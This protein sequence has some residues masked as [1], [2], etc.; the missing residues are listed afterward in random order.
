V[1]R[2]YLVFPAL[3]PVTALCGCTPGTMQH[4][5]AVQR[6]PRTTMQLGTSRETDAARPGYSKSLADFLLLFSAKIYLSR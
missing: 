1:P 6:R 5:D 3:I 4:Y 2:E